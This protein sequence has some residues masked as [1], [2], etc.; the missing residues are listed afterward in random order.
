MT[1]RVVP[2]FISIAILAFILRLLGG[3]ADQGAA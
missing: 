1:Q 2:F 3:T